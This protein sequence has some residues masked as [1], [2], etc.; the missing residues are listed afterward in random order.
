M[1]ENKMISGKD[2]KMSKMIKTCLVYL[3]TR[4]ITKLKTFK[5]VSNS[6]L[7]IQTRQSRN[8]KIVN[9]CVSSINTSLW[10]QPLEQMEFKNDCKVSQNNFH[11]SDKN[12]AIKRA[13]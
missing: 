13:I 6:M 4:S 12:N 5:V 7:Q 9:F 8:H 11:N 1:P 3:A 10:D 2:D